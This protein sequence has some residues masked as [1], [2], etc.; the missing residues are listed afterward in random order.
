V[1]RR[2]QS[3]L[4]SALI[5]PTNILITVVAREAVS[6]R[7][8]RLV[9]QELA[10]GDRLPTER[11]LAAELGVSRGAV[12]E[13]LRRLVDLGIVEAR[14][15]SGTYLSPVDLD[16]LHGVRLRVEPYAA[17]LA[18]ERRTAAHVERLRETLD[19]LRAELDDPAAFAEADLEIHR[20]VTDASDSVALGA[21]L[22]ALADLLR[23]SRERTA[24]ERDL[25]LHAL[26]ALERLVEAIE[27]GD[28]VGAERAMQAHLRDVG[29]TLRRRGKARG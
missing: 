25:R 28:A 20:T 8:R 7:L 17:R 5:G 2:S 24:P 14:Q 19:R 13:G 29:A 15:G 6:E 18:A 21:L 26:A 22:A 4:P 11:G 12:R 27:A 1:N 16:D 23:Q 9:E 10:P 3:H